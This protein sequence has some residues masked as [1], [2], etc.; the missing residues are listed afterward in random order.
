MMNIGNKF[1]MGSSSQAGSF[2]APPLKP[3]SSVKSPFRPSSPKRLFAQLSSVRK[4]NSNDPHRLE[5]NHNHSS[6]QHLPERALPNIKTEASE[7]FPLDGHHDMGRISL[8]PKNP[9]QTPSKALIQEIEK[10]LKENTF[11]SMTVGPLT[12]NKTCVYHTGRPTEFYSKVNDITAGFCSS[13]AVKLAGQC[14]EL[15]EVDLTVN[16][17]KPTRKEYLDLMLRK[18]E[19][20]KPNF[21]N[22]KAEF[23]NLKAAYQKIFT[24]K[25]EIL[26]KIFISLIDTLEKRK[27]LWDENLAQQFGRQ[28][29]DIDQQ[30]EAVDNSLK[31]VDKIKNDIVDNYQAILNESNFENFESIFE[32]HQ[33]L[34]D[35]NVETVRGMRVEG[36]DTFDGINV[37]EIVERTEA[38]LEK[39]LER[40]YNGVV[41][42]Q[43]QTVKLQESLKPEEKKPTQQMHNLPASLSLGPNSLLRKIG[44]MKDDFF[45]EPSNGSEKVISRNGKGINGLAGEALRRDREMRARM[46]DHE[47]RMSQG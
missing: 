33:Q 47:R 34:F 13:C 43:T 36:I 18:I 28:K 6:H 27:Y 39:E 5:K 7:D 42:D 9:S 30:I 37:K 45:P 17:A 20:S 25:K 1:G 21:S 23:R 16:K 4:R 29:K 8:T 2:R 19:L 46:Q 10:K 40:A 11:E 12:F 32:H 35:T 44:S 15:K 31:C 14:L 24:K 22:K 26:E 38:F 41:P 3:P